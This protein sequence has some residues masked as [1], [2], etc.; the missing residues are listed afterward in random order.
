MSDESQSS[1]VEAPDSPESPAGAPVR[2]TPGR[3]LR[4]YILWYALVSIAITAVWG[5][6]G[7]ILIPNQVQDLIFST[8]FLGGDAHVNL[9]QLTNLKAAVAAGADGIL[10]EV[11]PNADKAAS[12][13]MQT[14]Y[15][16]QFDQLMKELRLIATAVGRSM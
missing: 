2:Y 1:T 8:I 12:D 5:G 10:V 13:A 14:L 16:D 15:L 6:A 9:V 7:A 4:R 3:T 11:H